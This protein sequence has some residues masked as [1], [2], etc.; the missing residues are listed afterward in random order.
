[1]FDCVCFPKDWTQTHD[2]LVFQ[3]LKASLDPKYTNSKQV[4][5]KYP[6]TPVIHRRPYPVKY[7]SMYAY[8][9]EFTFGQ[10]SLT[11]R[12]IENKYIFDIPLFSCKKRIENKTQDFSRLFLNFF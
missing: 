6:A 3:Q 5:E 11:K 1:M 8:K 9:K 4:L 10:K 2:H 12:T 7:I